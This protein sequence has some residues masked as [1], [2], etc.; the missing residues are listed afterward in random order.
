M[1]EHGVEEGGR[2]GSLMGQGTSKSTEQG[3]VEEF[4]CGLMSQPEREDIS[5]Y[6]T[7]PMYAV[8][9]T[10]ITLPPT[11]GS[12]ARILVLISLIT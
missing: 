12:R 8:C 5:R 7:V 1:A 3:S 10:Y 4:D 9:K 11:G 2:D 6:G